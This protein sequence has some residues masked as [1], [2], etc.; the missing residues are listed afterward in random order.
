MDTNELLFILE[1]LA[2]VF[3]ILFFIG[4]IVYKVQMFMRKKGIYGVTI[5]HE[6][7][8]SDELKD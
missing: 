2:L 8:K 4:F 6:Y 3:G 5:R 1:V 7:T